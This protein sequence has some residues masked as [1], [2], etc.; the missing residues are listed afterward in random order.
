MTD[1]DSGLPADT[2]H[3]DGTR[4]VQTSTTNIGAY[5]WSALVA[6]E[7]GVVSHA[8]VVERL[9]KTLATIERLERHGPSGQ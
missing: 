1:G 5:M 8:E 2:L 9:G 6:E 4:S 3:Y 7:L